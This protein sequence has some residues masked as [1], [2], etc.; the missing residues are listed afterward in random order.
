MRQL[1]KDFVVAAS[2]IR[3]H[4]FNIELQSKFQV[5]EKAGNIVPVVGTT[6]AIIAWPFQDFRILKLYALISSTD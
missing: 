3:S 1:N 6:N 5:K 4:I 2:N